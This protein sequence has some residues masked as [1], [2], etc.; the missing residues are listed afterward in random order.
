MKINT[1]TIICDLKGKAIKNGAE[2]FTLG[3]AL[4]NILVSSKTG[5]KMKLYV[6]ATKLAQE[7]T[8]DVDDADFKM[9]KDCCEQ[10]EAY[11]PLISGQLLLL[12]ED[13]K[14]DAS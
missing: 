14:K 2:D 11:T 5:G 3:D 7:K 9:I 4:S 13:L 1:S 10:S 8:V 6:L 12:L